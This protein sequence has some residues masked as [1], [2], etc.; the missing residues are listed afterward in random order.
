V[1]RPPG[2]PTGLAA[3]CE[4]GVRYRRPTMPCWRSEQFG[5]TP[6]SPT[7]KGDEKRAPIFTCLRQLSVFAPA[8]SALPLWR[9]CSLSDDLTSGV[10]CVWSLSVSATCKSSLPHGFFVVTALP[11]RWQIAAHVFNPLPNFWVGQ[12]TFE[13]DLVERMAAG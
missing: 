1:Y 13:R 5:P 7:V 8:P 3:F 6:A 4:R 2:I 9:L 12:Q 10:V 11:L